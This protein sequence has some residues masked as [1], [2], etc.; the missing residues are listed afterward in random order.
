ME[1]LK[2][3][4]QPNACTNLTWPTPL[5]DNVGMIIRAIQIVN[6]EFTLCAR[7]SRWTAHR[8]APGAGCSGQPRVCT[9]LCVWCNWTHPARHAGCL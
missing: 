7:P 8:G 4:F 3:P 6:T 5:L 2:L 1:G 9:V